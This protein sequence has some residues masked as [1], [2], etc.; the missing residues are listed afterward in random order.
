MIIFYFIKYL[1]LRECDIYH[2]GFNLLKLERGQAN[3]GSMNRQP[4]RQLTEAVTM[5]T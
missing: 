4:K 3:I 1:S 2:F 5:P